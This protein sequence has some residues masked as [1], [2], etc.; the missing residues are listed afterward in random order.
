MDLVGAWPCTGSPA[1]MQVVLHG[2]ILLLQLCSEQ[3]EQEQVRGSRTWVRRRP[4][5]SP[6]PP[7][8]RVPSALGVWG[9]PCEPGLR[10]AMVVSG[11]EALC[12]GGSPRPAPSH[13]RSISSEEHERVLCPLCQTGRTPPILLLRAGAGQHRG[14]SQ[15]GPRSRGLTGR[16]ASRT[17]KLRVV[18]PVLGTEGQALVSPGHAAQDPLPRS[19]AARFLPTRARPWGT[20]G[21]RSPIGPF[22]PLCPLP[23][24]WLPGVW[25]RMS[26]GPPLASPGLSRAAWEG[27]RGGLGKE[28]KCFKIKRY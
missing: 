12:S 17:W 10:E 14:V 1:R 28:G 9:R 7:H 3:Q 2:I 18:A 21:R 27:V 19:R 11:R 24:S 4:T 13:P 16:S 23:C 8:P 20:A 25:G 22:S 15:C 6:A 5:P 26:T